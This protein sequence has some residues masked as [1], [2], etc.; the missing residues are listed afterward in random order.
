MIT[1][2]QVAGLIATL[3]ESKI[4]LNASDYGAKGDGVTDD[5]PAIQA[6][7]LAA[8]NAGGNNRA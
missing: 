3:A 6:A 1:Q 8:Y 2:N 5:Q 7:I 4:T